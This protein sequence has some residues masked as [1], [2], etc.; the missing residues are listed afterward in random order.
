MIVI[1]PD[2]QSRFELMH[3]TVLNRRPSSHC[4][5]VMIIIILVLLTSV[6]LSHCHTVRTPATPLGE[7]YAEFYVF[8]SAGYE[9]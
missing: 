1:A 2:L 6:T 7:G 5:R 8:P 3:S 4:M 9:T